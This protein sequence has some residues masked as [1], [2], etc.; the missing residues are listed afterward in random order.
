MCDE[1]TEAE[2]ERYL[3]QKRLGRREFGVGAGAAVAV[4]SAGC[5]PAPAPT[6]QESEPPAASAAP[7]AAEPASGAAPSLTQ[8]RVTIDTP[9]GT[10]EAFFVAPEGGRHPGVVLWPDVAGLRE[11]YETMA[12]RLAAQ[13]HAVVVFNQYYRS[14]KL[15]IVESFDEWRTEEGRARIAPMREAIT[16]EG[17]ARDGIAL[18]AWLDR[19][20]EV[21]TGR[22]LATIGYCMGGPFTVRTAAAVPERMGAIASFHGG[23]LVTDEP[24]SPH[25]LLPKMKAAALICIAHNDDERDPEAKSTLRQAAEAAHIE[26]EIEVYPA[27]H[28]WCTIDSP[29][30]DAEQAERAWARMLAVFA[31]HL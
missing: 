30:Y 28:G 10:A 18:A 9:D 23:G 12:A 22:K 5:G 17:I 4:L 29:V 20:P 21:D 1:T 27:Q 25:L 2:N 31:A 6:T 15:P 11:A 26:A 19:Q 13:G 7:A 8:R 16:P 24:S 14:S 3:E